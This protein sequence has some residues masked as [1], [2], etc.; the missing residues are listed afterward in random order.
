MGR[1]KTQAEVTALLPNL[2]QRAEIE[3]KK[4]NTTEAGRIKDL[5]RNLQAILPN[6]SKQADDVNYKCYQLKQ[7]EVV[8]LNNT[9]AY[10]VPPISY[11]A[12]IQSSYQIKP[13]TSN[14]KFGSNK[15][16][17]TPVCILDSL[18]NTAYGNPYAPTSYLQAKEFTFKED[19]NCLGERSRFQYIFYLHS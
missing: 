18:W 6:I 8:T 3:K 2:Q 1:E 11:A 15:L 16:S 9:I 4:M 13:D 12:Y 10:A 5:V 14:I 7:L 19:F 17:I